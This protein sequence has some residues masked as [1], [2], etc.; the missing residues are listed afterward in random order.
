M[1]RL[2]KWTWLILMIS[3]FAGCSLG[4]LTSC[5]RE[6]AAEPPPQMQRDLE[7]KAAE[8]PGIWK[9]LGGVV[10]LAKDGM[11][12]LARY[13]EKLNRRQ[14]QQA[15]VR[16]WLIVGAVVSGLFAL[17]GAAGKLLV[18]RAA[19]ASIWAIPLA[20]LARQAPWHAFVASGLACAGCIAL[21]VYLAPVWA[22]AIDLFW[23][24]LFVGAFYAGWVLSCR[25]YTGEWRPDGLVTLPAGWKPLLPGAA[26]T[27]STPN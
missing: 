14:E 18:G 3:L 13:V 21:A 17:A 24:A 12:D 26:S 16:R 23:V 27:R 4:A 5:R 7:K 11:Q 6:P 2:M 8:Y 22:I 10:T 20:W 1:R 9:I 19:A 15:T 25:R